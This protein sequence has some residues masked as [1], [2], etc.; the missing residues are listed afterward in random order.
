MVF[1]QSPMA[2][3]RTCLLGR[4]ASFSL[5]SIQPKRVGSILEEVGGWWA[6]HEC[7]GAPLQQ[8][9][10]KRV[11]LVGVDD[12]GRPPMIAGRPS[13]G[14]TPLTMWSTMLTLKNRGPYKVI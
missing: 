13:H 12:P 8:A 7:F 2:F 6:S 14:V 10:F 3:V 5:A 4:F 11:I 9:S 1:V